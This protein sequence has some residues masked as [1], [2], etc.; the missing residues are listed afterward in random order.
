[1]AKRFPVLF[2]V[3]PPAPK[4]VPG[5]KRTMYFFKEMNEQIS[6]QFIQGSRQK[7]FMV[8]KVEGKT[9][10]CIMKKKISTELGC[11]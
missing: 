5:T 6:I 4:R 2:I 11:I 7:G 3:V 9:N 10:L 1:M 8:I